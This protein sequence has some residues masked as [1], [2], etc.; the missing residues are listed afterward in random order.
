M[1]AYTYS[2]PNG[3]VESEQYDSLVYLM[4]LMKVHRLSGITPLH[5][6]SADGRFVIGDPGDDDISFVFRLQ[7]EFRIKFRD[8]L[9]ASMTTD[10]EAYYNR[11]PD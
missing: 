3:S 10:L 2:L 9:V 5:V 1:Y 4:Y 8:D 7:P 11:R 6:F